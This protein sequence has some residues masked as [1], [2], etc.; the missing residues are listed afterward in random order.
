MMP[1]RPCSG[2]RA[3]GGRPKADGQPPVVDAAQ[4]INGLRRLAPPGV[5]ARPAARR[6]PGEEGWGIRMRH[7]FDLA[8][9][10]RDVPLDDVH[11][12]LDHPAY[13]PRLRVPG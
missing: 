9:S 6:A 12:L 7:L 10:A 13:E 11:A 8:K 3:P 4:L 2:R 1:G 5:D